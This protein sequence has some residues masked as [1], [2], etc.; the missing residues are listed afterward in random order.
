MPPPRAGHTATLVDF[1]RMV[2][3]GGIGMKE[4]EAAVYEYVFDMSLWIRRPIIGIPPLAY[5]S[6]TL[7]GSGKIILFGGFVNGVAINTVYILDTIAWN[8][9]IINIPGGLPSPRGSHTAS[10]LGEQLW[11]SSGFS[12]VMTPDWYAIDNPYD[13]SGYSSSL[14]A[15][16]ATHFDNPRFADIKFLVRDT[17]IH[18]HKIVLASRCTKFREIFSSGEHPDVIRIEKFSFAPFRAF[19]KYLYSDK[20]ECQR[21][22]NK[23]FLPPPPILL[24]LSLYLYLSLNPFTQV[25]CKRAHSNC[26]VLSN[27]TAQSHGGKFL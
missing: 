27:T 2:V 12:D 4:A 25:S 6:A 16:L 26:S 11:I 17:L 21:W 18:C 23:N 8:I 22:V 13:S 10:L 19:L 1:S 5:H 7:V 9:T 15:D 14:G 24:Y 3:V 20:L